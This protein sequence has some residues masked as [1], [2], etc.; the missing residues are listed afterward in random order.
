MQ[1]SS[2]LASDGLSLTAGCMVGFT[3][4]LLAKDG[5]RHLGIGVVANDG[6]IQAPSF[7]G[8]KGHAEGG[9]SVSDG[10]IV[11]GNG[12]IRPNPRDVDSPG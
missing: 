10:S 3:P 7:N 8:S 9:S 12:P 5:T 2:R 4:F 6:A 11:L 1:A